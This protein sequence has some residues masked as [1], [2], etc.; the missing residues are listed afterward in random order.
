MNSITEL[1]SSYFSFLLCGMHNTLYFMRQP[2]GPNSQ[3]RDRH[4]SVRDHYL[5]TF[6]RDARYSRSARLRRLWT[7]PGKHCSRMASLNGHCCCR[8]SVCVSAKCCD[9]RSCNGPI[10]RDWRVG[11]RDGYGRRLSYNKCRERKMRGGCQRSSSNDTERISDRGS[12]VRKTLAKTLGP[13][14]IYSNTARR[15]VRSWSV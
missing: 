1:T 12:E 9:G 10:Y 4:N 7:C 13:V 2:M 14:I 6:L 15:T 3:K 5:C 8:I 11:C